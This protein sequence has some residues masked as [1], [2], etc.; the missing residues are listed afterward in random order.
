MNEI[1]QTVNLL[2]SR[3]LNALVT[4]AQT[5]QLR[6]DRAPALPDSVGYQ[7][8]IA[9]TR[10]GNWLSIIGQNGQNHYLN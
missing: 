10:I 8:L 3:Q 9:C 1:P 5:G 6:G 2:G 4:I 7:S